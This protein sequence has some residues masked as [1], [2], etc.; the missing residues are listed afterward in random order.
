MN[1]YLIIPDIHDRISQLRAIDKQFG[2]KLP[3]IYLGDWTDSFK[4]SA[5]DQEAIVDYLAEELSNHSRRFCWGN[6]D[7]HYHQPFN[8][9]GICGYT[10]GFSEDRLK[11]W[12]RIL[13]S[14]WPSRF[15]FYHF[16]GEYLISHAGFNKHPSEWLEKRMPWDVGIA[17]GGPNREGGPLWLDWN[18]EFTSFTNE[19]RQIQKQIVGHTVVKAPEHEASSFNLDTGLRYVGLLNPRG[20]KLAIHQVEGV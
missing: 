17:R 14:D 19:Y 1:G 4:G 18:L 11:L 5:A 10:S 9:S 7:W 6:H 8:P 2:R 15:E 3:R 13:P 20:S 16:I 12:Q